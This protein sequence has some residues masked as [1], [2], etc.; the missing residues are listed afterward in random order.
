LSRPPLDTRK[1]A[2]LVVLGLTVGALGAWLLFALAEYCARNR[3]P[4]I[5]PSPEIIA[6]PDRALLFHDPF[7]HLT[8][9]GHE[10]M[11]KLLLGRL[12]FLTA[13]NR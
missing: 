10:F 7:G 5:D 11:A 2:F 4:F 13:G 1:K 12:G 8:P 9:K 3:I 6:D